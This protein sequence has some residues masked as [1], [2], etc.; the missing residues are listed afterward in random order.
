MFQAFLMLKRE[1][2]AN[3]QS[4]AQ[5][6]QLGLITTILNNVNTSGGGIQKQLLKIRKRLHHE[7]SWQPLVKDCSFFGNYQQPNMVRPMPGITCQNGSLK[8]DNGS[9]PINN[10]LIYPNA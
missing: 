8:I 4:H 3:K 7:G 5:N 1:K 6:Q 10:Q 9:Q 2:L